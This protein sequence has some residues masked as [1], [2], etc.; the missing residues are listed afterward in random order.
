MEKI[1]LNK[2]TFCGMEDRA[3]EKREKERESLIEYERRDSESPVPKD[4]YFH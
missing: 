1:L 4:F 3:S 2:I